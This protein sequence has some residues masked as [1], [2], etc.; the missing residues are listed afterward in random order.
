MT[1]IDCFSSEE[2]DNE[3]KQTKQQ[4]P[5]HPTTTAV[6][7]DNQEQKS[8]KTKKAPI[9][10]SSTAS[11]GNGQK[12]KQAS[13]SSKP[14]KMNNQEQQTSPN[15]RQRTNGEKSEK[16]DTENRMFRGS[17]R[18]GSVYY[19][20]ASKRGHFE[21]WLEKSKPNAP[22]YVLNKQLYSW[23]D[24]TIQ[25]FQ[26]EFNHY[27]EQPAFINMYVNNSKAVSPANADQHPIVSSE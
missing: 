24:K 5:P 12:R 3:T 25:S 8:K 26:N 19:A 2:S 9:K 4:L 1:Y 14:I 20:L 11:S 13:A 15:K 21:R 7:P 6:T 23:M 27:C 16:S 22:T 17:N 18:V 10:K